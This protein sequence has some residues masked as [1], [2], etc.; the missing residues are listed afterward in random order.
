MSSARRLRTAEAAAYATG[1]GRNTS[2]SSLRKYRL[3]GPDDPGE[4]GP[5]WE[6]AP[7]GDCLYGVPGLDA[8][9]A[10]YLS[11]LRPAEPADQPSHLSRAQAA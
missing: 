4:H 10:E 2:A 11:A 7:N 1:L 5:P 9:V 6:R 3:R 8:W